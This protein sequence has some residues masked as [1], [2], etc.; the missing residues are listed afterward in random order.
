[1]KDSI[2]VLEDCENL[3]RSRDVSKNSSVSSILNL[4]DGIIGDVLNLKIIATLNTI[5]KIDTA[6]LRKGRMLCNVEFKPLTIEQAN[7]TAKKLN[8]NINI[9]NDT[10]LC[11][12]YNA[13]SNGVEQKQTM[14]IGF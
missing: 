14:K 3:L 5:D 12:I 6:L 2:L 9:I 13:E 1:M 8:K 7:T 4:T 11:D 10:C